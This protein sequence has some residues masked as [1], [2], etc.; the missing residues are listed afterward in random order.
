MDHRIHLLVGP[1]TE[2]GLVRGLGVT[3][4]VYRRYPNR[5]RNQS[6]RIRQNRFF[7]CLVGDEQYLWSVARY[8]ERHPLQ[9]RLAK[10]PEAYRWSSAKVHLTLKRASKKYKFVDCE[11]NGPLFQ[12]S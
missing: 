5:K 10:R 6:G 11:N 12:R 2:S 8:I 7:S 9:P 4:P 3:N 1:E